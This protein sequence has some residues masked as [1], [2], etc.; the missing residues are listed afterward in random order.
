M[1]KGGLRM[2]TAPSDEARERQRTAQGFALVAVFRRASTSIDKRRRALST[3]TSEHGRS[4]VGGGRAPAHASPA[5]QE[6][7][8]ASWSSPVVVL[9][10]GTHEE[11]SE[12]AASDDSAHDSH[13][14]PVRRAVRSPG[15]VMDCVRLCGQ[16]GSRL[17]L[18]PLR[19]QLA[20]RSNFT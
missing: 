3:E 10:Q 14:N 7:S 8:F 19:N 15:G 12:N 16:L 9:P 13:V 17:A 20:S 1:L 5:G 11:P 4:F 2:R 6:H 18:F